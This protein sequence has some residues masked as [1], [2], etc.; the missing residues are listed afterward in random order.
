[1][2]AVEK[3]VVDAAGEMSGEASDILREVLGLECKKLQ[4]EQ[5]SAKQGGVDQIE[6]GA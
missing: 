6:V 3:E 2:Q 1:M 4:Y 5:R